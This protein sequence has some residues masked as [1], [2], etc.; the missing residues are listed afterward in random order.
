MHLKTP[1]TKCRCTAVWTMNQMCFLLC[2]LFMSLELHFWTSFLFH[3]L[4]F[5]GVGYCDNILWCGID[6]YYDA[7][8]SYYYCNGTSL[9]FHS[10]PPP[11]PDL[12]SQVLQ[13]RNSFALLLVVYQ[14]ANRHESHSRTTILREP[15]TRDAKLMKFLPPPPLGDGFLLQQQRPSHSIENT[16]LQYILLITALWSCCIRTNDAQSV[17]LLH[18]VGNIISR[19][20]V[21]RIGV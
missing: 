19:N 9:L 5:F 3:L 2:N 11:L 17:F 12:T 7:R 13:H 4:F 18:Q 14:N 21:G 15:W 10:L 8:S 6:D 20:C 1:L 16:G